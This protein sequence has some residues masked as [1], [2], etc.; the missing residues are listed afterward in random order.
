MRKSVAAIALIR[1]QQ[2]GHTQWLAQ[3]NDHWQTYSLVGGHK[4]ADETFR[5]CLVR[6]VHEELGLTDRVDYQAP[7]QPL[8]CLQFTAWSQRAK[9][10][11]Q[12]TFE[13]FPVV[14]SSSRIEQTVIIDPRN[15]WLSGEELTAGRSVDGKAISP[16]FTRVLGEVLPSLDG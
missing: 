2:N 6:E 1:R 8:E 13:I 5:Q 15:R 12:Y 16:T 14:L 11:T 9:E 7:D 10:D 4:R 3:W